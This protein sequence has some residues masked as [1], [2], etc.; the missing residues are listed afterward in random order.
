VCG[1]ILVCLFLLGGL[2]LPALAWASEE[3]ELLLARGNKLYLEGKFTEAKDNLARAAKL[4]PNN[5]EIWS[6]LGTTDLALKNYQEAKESFTQTIALDPNYPQAKLYLG[7]ANYYLGDY[8][9]AERLLNEAKTIAPEE[10]LTHYYLGL[11]AAQQGR[12]QDALTNLELGMNVAPQFALGFKGYQ[13]ASQAAAPPTKPYFINFTTGIQYNDNVKVL[14][15]QTTI[16][17][18]GQYK[19]HKADWT[20]PMILYTG[21]EPVRTEQWVVGIR[22]YGYAGL[23]YYLSSFNTMDQLGEFYVKYRIDRLTINPYYT[24]NYTWLGGIPWSMINSGGLRLTLAETANLTGDLIYM[25]Q[26]RDFKYYGSQ[27][28]NAEGGSAYNRTGNL[29]QIGFFQT[30]AGKPGTLRVGFIWEREMTEGIN[31]TNNRY[32]FPVEGYLNLP[33]KLLAYGYFEYAHAAFN[34]RDSFANK[35]QNTN[36]FQ[37]ICQLRRPITSWMTA[38]AGF[39]H[40][41]NPSN[42]KDYQYN[43]NIYQL[44]MLFQY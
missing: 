32:R 41:S 1:F 40:I 8:P 31:F 23:N 34:N 12:H 9:E 24:F 17:G 37:V 38:I 19:G 5:T 33:W 29:S 39:S 27:I 20:T 11:A 10:G 36:Y 7:V 18:R 16:V 4:D 25:F 13:A 43:Q 42:I 21:Y 22:Y 2:L 30:L 26:N 3:S 14:P 44:L 35:Y 15:D 28:S 6:L